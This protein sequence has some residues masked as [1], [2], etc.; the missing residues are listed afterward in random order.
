MLFVAASKIQKLF[1]NFIM[2]KKTRAAIRLQRWWRRTITSITNKSL[3]L[4]KFKRFYYGLVILKF[5]SKYYAKNNKI[6]R[7][8]SNKKQIKVKE[9]RVSK[10]KRTRRSL[11]KI[12]E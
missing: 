9:E 3:K 1:R 2:K 11:L 7:N 8:E 4:Q 6:N 10:L 5:V 12:I